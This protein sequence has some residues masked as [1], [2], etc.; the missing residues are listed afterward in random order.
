MS[1][2]DA[3]TRR[4]PVAGEAPRKLTRAEKSQKIKRDLLAAAAKVVGKVGYSNA[5]VSRITAVANVGQGTF[6]NHFESRQ[7]LFDQLLPTLGGELL[8]F[9]RVRAADAPNALEREKRSFKAFFEFL[10][11]NPEFYRILY[12]AE[13][14]APKA[15]AAHIE[16]IAGAYVRTLERDA[17]QGGVAAM[18]KN[19]LEVLAFTLMGARHYL[20]M[21]FARKNGRVVDP[22]EWVVDTYMRLF[23]QG[24]SNRQ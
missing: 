16:R 11:E 7:D 3:A 19:A 9:I 18:D 12:E 13:V 1:M 22:P 10:K 15:F 4:R 20:C 21:R 23:A 2:R 24:I 5:Q 8:D 17:T 6:Y 14:F